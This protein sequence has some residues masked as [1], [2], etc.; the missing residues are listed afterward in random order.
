MTVEMA[1]SSHLG[2]SKIT[3]MECVSSRRHE[4][5]FQIRI[6]V[7]RAVTEMEVF[8][9]MVREQLTHVAGKASKVCHL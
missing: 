5:M 7:L 2:E 6:S 9:V 3:A 8:M 4:T 1:D